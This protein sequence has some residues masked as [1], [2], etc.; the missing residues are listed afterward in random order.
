MP[1]LTFEGVVEEGQIRLDPAVH[2]PEHT[3]VYVVVPGEVAT[4]VVRIRSPRLARP[5]DAA[6]FRME[7]AEED[8]DA[9]V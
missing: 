5:G 8:T 1:V 2:L 4:A 9:G 6:A 3:R 7:I